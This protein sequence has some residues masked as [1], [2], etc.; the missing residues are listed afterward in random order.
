M[1]YARLGTYVRLTRADLVRNLQDLATEYTLNSIKSQEHESHHVTRKRTMFALSRCAAARSIICASASHI[2]RVRLLCHWYTPQRV[3]F[4]NTVTSVNSF[5][6]AYYL[7]RFWIVSPLEA[8][9]AYHCSAA[10]YLPLPPF[11]ELL[12]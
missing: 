4:L 7:L 11:T 5:L 3:S 2:P 6:N 12:E 10:H 9:P 1:S 8:I